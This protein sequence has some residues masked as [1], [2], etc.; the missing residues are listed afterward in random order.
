[1]K[2]RLILW[3]AVSATSAVFF[4]GLGGCI[5]DLLFLVAPILL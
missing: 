1:M 5:Q 4:L 2:R 3:A